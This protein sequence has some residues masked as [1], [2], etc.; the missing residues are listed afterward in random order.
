MNNETLEI[1]KEYKYLGIL[2]SSSGSFLAA[3]KLIAAQ[4]TRAM[5]CLLKK[6]R[7][8]LLPIYIQIDLFE[9]T[10]KPILPYWCEVIGTD[11]INILEQVQRKCLKLMLNL[12]TSTPNCMVYGETGVMPL[13]LDVQCRII[14]YWSKLVYPTTNNLSSKLYA[15]ALSH[16]QHSISNKFIWLENVKNILISCGFSGFWDMHTFPNRN[17]LIKATK[18]NS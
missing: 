5:F 17:W 6:A 2:F 11:N 14:S 18:Q 3:K 10:V 16:F 1:V 13:K 15:V 8:L 12:K 4:A 7:S 9:K